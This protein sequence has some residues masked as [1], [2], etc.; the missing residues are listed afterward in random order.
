M[1]AVHVSAWVC[2]TYMYLISEPLSHYDIIDLISLDIPWNF[3]SVSFFTVN[4]LECVGYYHI[5]SPAEVNKTVSS[6]ISS[7]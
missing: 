7:S 4:I 2:F 1:V 6:F 3:P 5:M